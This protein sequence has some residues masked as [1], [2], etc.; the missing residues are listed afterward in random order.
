MESAYYNADLDNNS[1]TYGRI[2]YYDIFDDRDADN[3]RY[4]TL[5]GYVEKF[6]N[7]DDEGRPRIFVPHIFFVSYGEIVGGHL[8]TVESVTD[9]SSPLTTEQEAELLGIYG[10]MIGDMLAACNAC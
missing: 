9:P 2:L 1:S 8:D 7:E 4:Q 5:V 10:T 6:L 3:E